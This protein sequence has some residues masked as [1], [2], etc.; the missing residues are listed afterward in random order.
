MWWALLTRKEEQ[1]KKQLLVKL[2]QDIQKIKQ[3][4]QTQ[5]LAIYNKSIRRIQKLNIEYKYSQATQ[6]MIHDWE[7]SQALSMLGALRYVG[8]L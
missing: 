7:K 4:K 1:L 2:E 8:L 3:K 5:A 6:N